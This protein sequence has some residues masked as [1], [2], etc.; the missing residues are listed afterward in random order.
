[1]EFRKHGDFD[2]EIWRWRHGNI[3]TFTV[4]GDMET[5]ITGDMETWKHQTENGSQGDFL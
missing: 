5:W 3:E 1:L 2:T 4:Y